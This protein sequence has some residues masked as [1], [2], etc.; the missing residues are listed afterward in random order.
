MTCDALRLTPLEASLPRTL[1]RCCWS[2]RPLRRRWGRA[3]MVRPDPGRPD[4]GRDCHCCCWRLGIGPTEKTGEACDGPRPND[5]SPARWTSAPLCLG[6]YAGN[7][8]TKI[9]IPS[10]LNKRFSGKKD[11]QRADG[12]QGQVR[13]KEQSDYFHL[14]PLKMLTR[15]AIATSN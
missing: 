9:Q 3:L 6:I 15:I 7:F 5:Y 1:R 12:D 11:R 8:R 14:V 13:L 2:V 10:K 4:P